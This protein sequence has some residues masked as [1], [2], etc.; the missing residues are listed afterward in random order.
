MR[1]NYKFYMSSIPVGKI[2]EKAHC[3]FSAEL[4]KNA[5]LQTANFAHWDIVFFVGNPFFF[6]NPLRFLSTWLPCFSLNS[7]Y[8]RN[9]LLW[10]N[11]LF[12]Y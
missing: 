8:I 9:T 6:A 5:L 3:I 4:T 2:A 1:N 10:E 12:F 7:L 11:S